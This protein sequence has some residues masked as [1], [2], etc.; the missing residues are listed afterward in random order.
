[1][2]AIRMA[3]A[4]H[5]KSWMQGLNTYTILS[6]PYHRGHPMHVKWHNDFYSLKYFL[7]CHSEQG[8]ESF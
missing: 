3:N 1:M 4:K 2:T 5:N 6:N 7:F 8:E